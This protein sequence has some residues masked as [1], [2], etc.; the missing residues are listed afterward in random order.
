M[1]QDLHKLHKTQTGT[2]THTH[3]TAA[4][5]N[6]CNVKDFTPLMLNR[7]T[8][9]PPSPYPLSF[10][11]PSIRCDCLC[12]AACPSVYFSH[13]LLHAYCMLNRAHRV[14]RVHTSVCR[15]MAH[16]LKIPLHVGQVNDLAA[17]HALCRFNWPAEWENVKQFFVLALR[18]SQAKCQNG[19]RL[20]LMWFFRI[21]WASKPIGSN[22]SRVKTNGKVKENS[23]KQKPRKQKEENVSNEKWRAQIFAKAK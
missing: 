23:R 1:A 14:R 18:T 13:T 12:H 22:P 6:M 15:R 17:M 16:K 2:H 7:S 3:S 20:P 5:W 9:H 8:K 11:F 21:I 19:A 4:G 10:P